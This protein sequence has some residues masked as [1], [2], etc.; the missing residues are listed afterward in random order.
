MF[1]L[2]EVATAGRDG[3]AIQADVDNGAFGLGFGDAATALLK[4]RYAAV[5]G[6]KGKAESRA[7]VAS[8]KTGMTR[9][10]K[11]KISISSA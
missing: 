6:D 11:V 2:R 3:A 7:S 8:K 9:Y 10:G 4:T 1:F 5:D